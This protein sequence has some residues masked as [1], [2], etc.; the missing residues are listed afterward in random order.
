MNKQKVISIVLPA[1]NEGSNVNVVYEHLVEVFEKLPYELQILYVN[2]GSKDDT[3]DFLRALAA[4][5]SRVD[6]LSFSRNFGHQAAV[7]AGYYYAVGDAVISMDCDMQ[8]PPRMLP[9]LLAKWEEGYEVVYTIRE[10]DKRLGWFKRTSSSTF[11]RVVNAL[12]DVKI[13]DGAADFRLLDRKVANVVATLSEDDPF[14]R[15]M[16]KWVGFKQ[17]AIPYRPDERV[18][19]E[20]KYTLS[21]MF[22]LAIAGVTSFSVRP[23][24]LAIWIGGIVTFLSL[25]LVPYVIWSFFTDHVAAGWSSMM[26]AIGFLGGVQLLVLGVVGLYIGKI[27]MQTKQRPVFIVSEMSKNNVGGI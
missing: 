6:Y 17:Y 14:L 25:L 13:E 15:G 9:E 12:S 10:Q 5:D 16:I 1:Y 3:L 11:Y 7:K 18:A 20:S 24:H 21:K 27:F 2:D 8:H 23:L 26:L 22:K 4:K 19:G